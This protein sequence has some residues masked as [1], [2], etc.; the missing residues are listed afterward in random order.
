MNPLSLSSADVVSRVAE[1][2]SA[3]LDQNKLCCLTHS[4]YGWTGSQNRSGERRKREKA[5]VSGRGRKRIFCFLTSTF[6]E[7][8]LATYR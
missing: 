2:G 8:A 4:S 6:A 1:P 3:L 5:G 7:A